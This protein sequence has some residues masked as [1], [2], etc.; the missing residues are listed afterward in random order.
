MPIGLVDVAGLDVRS[1]GQHDVGH[2]HRVRHRDIAA[3]DKQIRLCQ[4]FAHHG[5]LGM[6]G[7]RIVVVDE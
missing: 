2:G 5:L 3:D 6:D 4:R 7:D 1:G